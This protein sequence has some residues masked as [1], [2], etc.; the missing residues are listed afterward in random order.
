MVES[1]F[2]YGADLRN[3]FQSK[4]ASTQY[5]I[6]IVFL[7]KPVK[8]EWKCFRK[9][10]SNASL[11]WYEVQH[12]EI[13]QFLFG[14]SI[15]LLNKHAVFQQLSHSINLLLLPAQYQNCCSPKTASK[16]WASKY[17]CLCVKSKYLISELD[18]KATDYHH[19]GVNFSH[20]KSSVY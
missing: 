14:G 19:Q 8:Y 4:A 20:W 6:Y 2:L 10:F 5:H 11:S 3:T 15:L 17:H 16:Q 13:V 7:F 18:A 12:S 1:S 9:V